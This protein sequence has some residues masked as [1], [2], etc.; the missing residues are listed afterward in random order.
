MRYLVDTDWLIDAS[1]NVSRVVRT[2]DHLSAEGLA[3]SIITVAEIYEGAFGL[4]DPDAALAAF[5]AFLAGYPVVPLDED[6]MLAF[7]RTRSRM[8]RQGELIP[9]FDL[10][11]AAT[12]IVHDLTLLTRNL[13][14]FERIPELRIYRAG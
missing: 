4:P 14:H 9:D 5:H 8:R 2:L 11:I 3:V 10:L 12:A 6:I 13:R 1:A 7:A